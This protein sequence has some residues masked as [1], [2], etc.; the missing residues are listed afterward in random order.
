M[1]RSRPVCALAAGLLSLLAAARGQSVFSAPVATSSVSGQFIV[2]SA[3]EDRPYFRRPDVGTNVS[4]L[5]LE[6]SLLAVSAEHFKAVLWREIGLAP[7]SSW[8]GKIFLALHPAH[9]LDEPV[10][11][12]TQPFVRSWNY[13]VELPDLISRTRCARAFSAV[14]LLELANRNV[15][16]DGRSATLPNWLVDG[17]ARQ[18]LRVEETQVILSSPTKVEND[19]TLTRFN[20]Q[21]RGLDPLAEVRRV[22]QSAPALTFEQLS[23]PTAAQVDGQDG[24]VY[25]ASAQLFV[26]DLLAL[27]DGPAKLLAFLVQLPARENWQAAFFDAFQENFRRPLEVEKWWALRVVT[28]VSRDPGPRWT[29]AVSRE[30][31]DAALVVPV[32]VRSTSNALPS[33]VEY[34][35]QAVLRSF[36]PAR[37][38]ELFQLR[39]RDLDLIQ[40][41][42]APELASVADGYRQLLADFLG[43]GKRGLFHRQPGTAAT[44]KQLDVLDVRRHEV[45][46]KLKT[47]VLPADLNLTPP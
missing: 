8:S 15:P 44:I 25:L 1:N 31:L 10:L 37:Q 19:I 18:V 24:G 35:L 42:L 22:L 20:E 38:M 5:R 41:R 27:K 11:L 23:W 29:P 14:L 13:R 21:R 12:T 46:S 28:F 32:N 7:G 47:S 4:V 45:E 30:K 17:L 16:I 33:Y 2:S 34:S 39:R 3:S 26:S 6:P 43:E 9:A 36:P 40:L